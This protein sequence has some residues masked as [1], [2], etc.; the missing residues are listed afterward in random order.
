MVDVK[1]VVTIDQDATSTDRK[2]K[3]WDI[4]A[5][6]WLEKDVQGFWCIRGCQQ[7]GK[8]LLQ[9][10]VLIQFSFVGG[11]DIYTVLWAS[12]GFVHRAAAASLAVSI[13]A[14]GI[15]MFNSLRFRE[16]F[17]VFMLYLLVGI[18]WAS[19]EIILKAFSLHVLNAADS[20]DGAT[21]TILVLF[22]LDLTA[23]GVLKLCA[24]LWFG[25]IIYLNAVN[26]GQEKKGSSSIGDEKLY[27]P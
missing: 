27:D 18:V 19:I 17:D 26:E 23:F 22:Y 1:R 20:G 10:L 25:L 16:A 7:R 9:L 15:N 13:L 4:R 21:C 14:S 5:V 3:S 8:W 12:A 24:I 11:V 2:K 6:K